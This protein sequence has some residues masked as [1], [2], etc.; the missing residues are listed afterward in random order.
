MPGISVKI[1]DPAN[2]EQLPTG[3]EGLLLA[4]GPNVMLGYANQSELTR[5]VM[6]DGWYNTGDFA[7]LDADG[8]LTLTSRVTQ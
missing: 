2:F 8:F 5:R 4:R 3:R 1:V 6:I 7:R